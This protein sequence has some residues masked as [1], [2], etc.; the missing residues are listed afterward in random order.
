M[1]EKEKKE[2]EE[3]EKREKQVKEIEENEKRKGKRKKREL[4]DLSFKGNT[5]LSHFL[6]LSREELFI[7]N[8]WHQQW[9]KERMILPMKYLF[10]NEQ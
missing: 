3:E 2:R 8:E 1:E 9:G 10:I 5:N 4:P 6:L 7:K